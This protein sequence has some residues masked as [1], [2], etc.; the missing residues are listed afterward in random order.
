MSA[1]VASLAAV[2]FGTGDFLGGLAA[3]GADWRR[4]VPT[5][6]GAG[7]PV[8]GLAAWGQALPAGP[9]ALGWCGVAGA[10]FALG[11]SLLYRALAEGRMTQVAPITA[12][13]AIALPALVDVLNGKA[14]TAPLV[15][16]LAAASLSAAL[17]SGLGG[18]W[19]E[20]LR[21][22]AVLAAAL[23]SGLGL[24]LFYIGLDRAEAAGGGIWAALLIRAI[25]FAAT[26]AAGLLG[27]AR[28]GGA[29]GIR[30]AL[31]AG[32]ADGT[33]NLLL[34]LAFAAG[35]LAETSAIVSL[36][37]VA[38]ILLAVALLRERPSAAQTIGLALVIPAI[39]LLKSG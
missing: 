4:V 32:L 19:R 21:D 10:G 31:C 18:G 6:I 13:V 9:L 16:G 29:G 1:L 26:A 14:V 33:A 20:T 37:P 27:R 5:A 30:L 2:A 11:I 22:R 25:A 3:R 8:L 15:L 38:T 12:I 7:L 28:P 24:A 23:A 36:Y 34:M 39:L 17:L 35:G